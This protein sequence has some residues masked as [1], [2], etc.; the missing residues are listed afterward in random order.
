MGKMSRDKGARFE[1]TIANKLKDYGY[2]AM[3][4][5]QHCGKSGDAADVIGLPGIHIEC[6]AQ[7]KM[8]LYEWMAQAERDAEGTGNIPTV[9]H[10][11]NNMPI[12]VTLKFEDFME[13][14]GR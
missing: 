2:K 5:A 1:R 12:L 13:L 3:R 14:Y 4:T 6:K 11:Q 10:K 7:E 9:V 8:H